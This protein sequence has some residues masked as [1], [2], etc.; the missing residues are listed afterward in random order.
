MNASAATT[1]DVANLAASLEPGTCT[2][3]AGRPSSGHR[4]LGAAIAHGFAVDGG[5]A[6]IVSAEY[7]I[8][9]YRQRYLEPL[10][11]ASS[12]SISTARPLVDVS[13]I[14]RDTTSDLIVVDYITLIGDETVGDSAR[15]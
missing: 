4:R 7:G 11:E 14:L 5:R 12:V 9:E 13:H 15:A 1:L 6:H 10:G 8:E 2:I 3:L